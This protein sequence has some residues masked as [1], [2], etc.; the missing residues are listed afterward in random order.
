MALPKD[1]I[2][3]LSAR[4]ARQ[5]LQTVVLTITTLSL[6]SWLATTSF[7]SETPSSA[8]QPKE[9]GNQALAAL[10][11]VDVTAAPFS[12]DPQGEHDSTVA[13]Q[14]AIVFARDQ[15]MVCFFPPGEYK[16]SDTLHCEQYRPL[17]RDGTRS[18]TR[19]YPCVLIGSRRTATR[20]RIVLAARSPGFSDPD[21]PKYVIHFRA[22]GTGR[23]TPVDQLQPNINMNQMLVGIDVTIGPDNA[24][25][26]G[27]RHRAA[28]G[29]GVQDCT[30]DATHGYCGLEG[31][32]GSGGSHAN[33]T[34]IGGRIGMDMRQTQPAPT[35]TGCTL[36]RTDGN[37]LDCQ[38]PAVALRRRAPYRDRYVRPGD[39]DQEAMGR[40]SRTALP[41]RQPNHF[42]QSRQEHGDRS[43]IQPLLEQRLHPRRRNPGPAAEQTGSA[44]GR[45]WLG[46]CQRVRRR[47]GR[48]VRRSQVRKPDVRLPGVQFLW[49]GSL[50][51]R[52]FSPV[53][54]P[55]QLRQRISKAGSYGTSRFPVGNRPRRSTSR[56]RRTA[57]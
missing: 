49:T 45:F 42:P 15:Q 50:W 54:K 21:N 24:G 5:R 19:D 52:P 3:G 36:S 22:M 57:P 2:R 48:T 28:Q 14:Q 6:W 46:A 12:A 4:E 11:F 16:I 53:W 17:R 32:A 37:R 41:D 31:G 35:L 25:A 43:R 44:R 30:I 33:V 10:G 56:I 13:I 55:G 34:V 51:R 27:I 26:V 40:A 39:R 20:P 8:E 29:S 23:E 7:A 9:L 38:Q 1:Q 47:R 18:G